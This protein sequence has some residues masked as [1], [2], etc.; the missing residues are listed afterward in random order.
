MGSYPN[1]NNKPISP[2]EPS[3]NIKPNQLKTTYTIIDEKTKNLYNSIPKDQYLCPLCGDI[4]ELKNIHTDNGFIEFKCKCRQESLLLSVEQYFQKLSECN[5]TYYNIKCS[6]CNKVQKNYINKNQIFKFCYECQKDYCDDCLNNYT[7]HPKNHLDKCIPVSEKTSR[8]LEHF[9]EGAYTSFCTDCHRHVC[10]ESSTKMHRGHNK[11]NLFKIDPKKKIIVHKNKI[12]SDI[13]RFN[14]LIL[15][16]YEQFPD[17]YFHMINLSNLANSINVENSRNSKELESAFRGLELKIKERKKAI[18]EFNKKYKLS[19]NGYEESLSLNNKGLNDDDFKLI[20]QIH[21]PNLKDLDISKNNIKDI[22][23]LKNIDTSNLEYLYMND[24]KIENI[25]NFDSLNLTKLIELG[26]QNN[27]IKNVSPLLKSNLPKIELLRIEGNNEID[28]SLNDFKKVIKK[29]TKAII[30][31]VQSFADFNKKYGVN[32]TDQSPIID[33]R[34]KETGNDVIRDLY[35]LSS[36]Y[37]ETKKLILANNKID[38]ISILSRISFKKLETL[39]LSMNKLTNVDSLSKMKFKNL[40]YLYLNDNKISYVTLLK[41]LNLNKL[42][43]V[44]LKE[45]NIASKNQEF[46][47]VVKEL[48]K[49][50][51]NIEFD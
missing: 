24:N 34:D 26:L 22:S 37:D 33:L 44:S 39:D 48:K 6:A 11:I 2:I 51:V 1:T 49:T 35:L 15:H 40:K 31:S 27:N 4:P 42:S 10:N 13:I 32:I 36:K 7:N 29:Y 28:S 17:N 12:L 5:F 20:S 14:E 25:D 18:E 47:N 41:T 9:K 30:Y 43:V 45:N 50:T 23:P 8:C 19:L 38:D 3:T 16:T 21:F 46:Q